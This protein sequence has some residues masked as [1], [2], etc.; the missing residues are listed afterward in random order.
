VR[1]S[2]VR[3]PL[4][5]SF[6]EK[7]FLVTGSALEKGGLSTLKLTE[8]WCLA[9]AAVPTGWPGW[10]LV[11]FE[12]E[13]AGVLGFVTREVPSVMSSQIQEIQRGPRGRQADTACDVRD[14][15]FFNV[16][17]FPSPVES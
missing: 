1:H 7:L 8:E 12:L 15:F 3:V 16:G 9:I 10:Y 4:H 14:S 11:T 2:A 17:T 6:V 13:L 5:S